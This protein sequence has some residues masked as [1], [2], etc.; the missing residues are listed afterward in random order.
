MR[1]TDRTVAKIGRSTKKCDRFT[2]T[3]R[4]L[5]SRSF[6]LS[7]LRRHLAAG[8][9]P[10]QPVDDDAVARFEA[11][12]DDAQAVIGH[13]TRTH[14]LWLD[15]AVLLHG[16]HQLARLIGDDGAVGD[17]DRDM[18]LRCRDANPPELPG[19]DKITRIWEDAASADRPGAAVHLIIEEVELPLPRPFLLIGQAGINRRSRLPRLVQHASGGGALIGEIIALAHVEIKIDRVERY[20]G[21]ERRGR[22]GIAAAD[23]IPDAHLM[24][25]DPPGERCGDPGEPDIELGRADRG[26]GGLDRGSRDLEVRD[27][28]VV[29]AGRLKILFAQ[30]GGA[31][32]LPGGELDL[33]LALGELRPGCR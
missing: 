14:D 2:G 20:D 33:R 32:E 28:L 1:N 6:D 21:G 31:P 10:H 5:P 9:R 18:L 3:T 8:T 22:G 24:V 25:A 12:A 16:H 23:Q 13:W 19:S 11:R 27:P 17:Q 30:L 15:G 29:G 26:L 7:W 4:S